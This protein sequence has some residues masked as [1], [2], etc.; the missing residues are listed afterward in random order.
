MHDI[1]LERL[2]VGTFSVNCYLLGCSKSQKMAV[3]DPGGETDAIWQKI[4]TIGYSF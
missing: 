2:I 1:I 4:Q 3:I